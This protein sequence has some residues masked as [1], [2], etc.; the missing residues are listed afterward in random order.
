MRAGAASRDREYELIDTGI[1]DEDR[2]FDVEV[3]YAKADA[4]DILMRVTVHQSR[5]RSGRRSTSCRKPGSATSGA[6]RTASP[7]AALT[8]SGDGAVARAA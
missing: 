8:R 3:E 4:D 5:A 7:R 2:Y 6:G 1:F